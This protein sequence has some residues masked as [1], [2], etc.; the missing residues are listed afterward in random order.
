VVGVERDL[1]PFVTGTA[2][3]APTT[4]NRAVK[5]ITVTTERN[6]WISTVFLKT[7]GDQVVLDLLVDEMRMTPITTPFQGSS[8]RPTMTTGT[9]PRVAPMFGIRSVIA[10]NSESGAA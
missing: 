10:T 8:R 9:V 4:P 7:F 2:I 3:R 5:A 6:G 1:M